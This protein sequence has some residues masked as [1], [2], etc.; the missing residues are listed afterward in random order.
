MMT[1]PASPGT[2]LFSDQPGHDERID[3]VVDAGVLC[4]IFVDDD[5]QVDLIPVADMAG[6]FRALA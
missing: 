2:Y 4:A 1:T 5:G 3:V 6:T